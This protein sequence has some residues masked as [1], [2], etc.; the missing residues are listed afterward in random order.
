MK[1]RGKIIHLDA[2]SSKQT[3]PGGPS[4]PKVKE[5]VVQAGQREPPMSEITQII[6]DL[7]PKRWERIWRR[8]QWNEA[9]RRDAILSIGEDAVYVWQL[10]ES[11]RYRHKTA[12]DVLADRHEAM[13]EWDARNA[14]GGE[15]I[16]SGDAHKRLGWTPREFQ[17][18]WKRFV[19]QRFDPEFELSLPFIDSIK[20]YRDAASKSKERIRKALVRQAGRGPKGHA[21]K[22]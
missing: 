12:R 3:A 7:F 16:R 4:K 20:A 13:K 21:S 5:R 11:R 2:D 1:A 10:F 8:G 9:R 14:W 18:A 22:K 17:A 15:M 19:P 6:H